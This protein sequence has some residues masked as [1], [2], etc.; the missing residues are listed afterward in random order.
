MDNWIIFKVGRG[1]C[2][3]LGEVGVG[4]GLVVGEVDGHERHGREQTQP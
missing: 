3:G 4:W 1:L 2:G